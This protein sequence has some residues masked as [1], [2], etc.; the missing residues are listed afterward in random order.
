MKTE[1]AA[2]ARQYAEAMLQLALAK[3]GDKLADQIL[4]DLRKVNETLKSDQFKALRGY[5]THPSVPA[6]VKKNLLTAMFT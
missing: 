6:E 1:Q 3:G 4:S 5:F 2:A